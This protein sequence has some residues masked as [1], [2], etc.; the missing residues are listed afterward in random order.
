MIAISAVGTSSC[1]KVPS[2]ADLKR[3]EKKAIDR[4]IAEEGFEILKKY[5]ADGVFGEKQFVVLDNGVYLN[6]VD[7]GNGRRA[8][9]GKTTILMRCSIRLIFKADTGSYSNFSNTDIPIEFLYG[10]AANTISEQ[11]TSYADVWLYLSTGVESALKYVGENS[12]VKLIVPFD[13]GSS[14]QSTG[15]TGSSSRYGAPL[16]YDKV[17]FTF[18]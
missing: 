18:Y 17:K 12:V 7:S 8:V 14:Y 16:Y 15:L 5:P 10:Y 6:V 13:Y 3:D 9:E 4:L 1:N 11:A 2:Y